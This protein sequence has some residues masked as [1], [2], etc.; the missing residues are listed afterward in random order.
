MKDHPQAD[1]PAVS[2]LQ[3]LRTVGGAGRWP[4]V[5]LKSPEQT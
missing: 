1:F 2:A 3:S 5:R 4:R